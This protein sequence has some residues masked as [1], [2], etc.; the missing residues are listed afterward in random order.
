MIHPFTVTL[1]IPAHNEERTLPQL[2]SAILRQQTVGF[3]LERI[4]VV[5]DG[6][7]DQTA[8]VVRACAQQDDRI[9]L[10]DDGKHTGKAERLNQLYRLNESDILVTLDADIV[11]E[12]EHV[13]ETLVAPLRDP[14][15][16]VVAGNHQPFP[17]RTLLGNIL[18]VRAAWWYAARRDF[19]GGQN[20]YNSAGCCF[21]L[22]R[23]FTEHFTFLP[24][25]LHDEHIIYLETVAQ[26][27]KFILAEQAVVRF[28]EAAYW[29][30]LVDRARRFAYQDDLAG[31]G[32]TFD[33]ATLPALPLGRKLK[34]VFRGLLAHPI[35][36]PLSLVLTV[37]LKLALLNQHD[38]H[39]HSSG[40]WQTT[41]STKQL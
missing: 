8:A 10:L 23:E 7:T 19:Q 37:V 9:Q 24:G 39:R 33:P 29:S 1:G 18:V 26:Q 41:T 20:Q 15:V 16:A 4:V 31:Y 5:L 35:L 11:L 6:C 3:T 40:L 28:R 17:G 14:A 25:T 22:R 12:H 27:K 34:A 13:L 38:N 2:L 36:V 30:E 21:A 32:F